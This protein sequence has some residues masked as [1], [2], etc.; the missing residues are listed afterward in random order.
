MCVCVLYVNIHI[1][2]YCVHEKNDHVSHKIDRML[3][4]LD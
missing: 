4:L 3:Y 1:I 2:L